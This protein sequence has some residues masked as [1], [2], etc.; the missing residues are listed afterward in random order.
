L[1]FES[2][3]AFEERVGRPAA[4]PGSFDSS[5]QFSPS[6]IALAILVFLGLA[7]VGWGIIVDTV[8]SNVAA[9]D[10]ETAVAWMP[11]EPEALDELAIREIA[12]SD[13]DLD[14]ARGLAERALRSNPLDARALSIL[15]LIAE[16]QGDQ[17]RADILMRQ[18]AGRTWRDTT[19]QAWLVNRD[20]QRGEFEQALSHIDALLRVYPEVNEQ[21]FPVLAAF[22]IDQRTFDVL[23]NL[24]AAAP[25]WRADFLGKLSSQMPDPGRLVQL[26]AVLKNS[27]H[28][29]DAAELR[30]YLDRL[31]RDGRFAEAYQSWRDTLSPQ[32][33]TR[34]TYPYNGNFA[35]PVDGLPFNWL[36][37]PVPGMDIQIV[38]S[39]GQVE[40]RKL[41]LQFSGARVGEFTVGQLML[42][43]PG[44]YRL[45]GKVRA[46]EL[47]TQRGLRWHIFCGTPPNETLALTNLVA[48]SVPWSGFS[49]D[50][51]VPANN[52]SAEWLKLELPARTASE[53]QIEGQVWYENLQI[54]RVA[55]GPSPGIQ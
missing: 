14:T 24:L 25:P 19:T 41:Q 46:E 55:K 10:P 12:N 8:G 40:S 17:A 52:C 15:G 7:W 11:N 22:T 29:P 38:A 39:P 43:P 37:R 28:P 47:H 33:R 9:T 45:T 35:A 21:T 44:E 5:I 6:R 36:L 34:E 16:R 27:P 26:Y 31:I 2:G 32:Q 13:G 23:A 53:R 42:L 3:R 4:S 50:F 30:P 51:T 18:S 48:D 49:V 54:E 1:Q 20:I